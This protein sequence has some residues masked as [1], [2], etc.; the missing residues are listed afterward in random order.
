MWSENLAYLG[1][2]TPEAIVR[3]ALREFVG[4]G[5]GGDEEV[6]ERYNVAVVV[7]ALNELLKEQI[8]VQTTTGYEVPAVC[9]EDIFDYIDEAIEKA[10]G[11]SE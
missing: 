4:D 6:L 1:D 5:D 2:A 3:E 11:W 7:E 9:V 10:G 8:S